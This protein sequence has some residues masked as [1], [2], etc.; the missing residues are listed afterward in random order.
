MLSVMADEI[1]SFRFRL[2]MSREPHK[3]GTRS[4]LPKKL[5]RAALLRPGLRGESSQYL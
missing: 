4:A 5:R 2:M 1:R 3:F